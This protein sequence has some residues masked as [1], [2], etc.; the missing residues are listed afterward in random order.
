[1]KKFVGTKVVRAETMTLGAY[2]FLRG[3]DMPEGEDP[4]APGYLV[5]YLDGGK[6]NHPDYEH[7][8]SWSPADVFEGSY[9]PLS[10]GMD[11]GSALKLLKQGKAVSRRG[12]NGKGMFVY[13]VGAGRYP[14]ST[15]TGELLAKQ[16]IDGK[17]PYLP[18]LALK[19]VN[20]EVVPWL[21]SQTDVLANDWEPVV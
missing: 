3:W 1:M 18:Y 13:L 8:I 15:P 12:W 21:A 11:F 16:Q 4:E 14:P 6:P 17:V 19:S 10:P 9:L 5:E 2:N 7:Y 20:G